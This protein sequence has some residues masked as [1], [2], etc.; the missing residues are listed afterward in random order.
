MSRQILDSDDENL[1]P[2]KR[3]NSDGKKDL[4]E[5]DY[6]SEQSIS[7]PKKKRSRLT[8][9]SQVQTS[10]SDAE[11]I[12]STVASNAGES[13]QGDGESEVENDDRGDEQ[14]G[15]KKRSEVSDVEVFRR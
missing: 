6:N 9:K 14:G 11:G 7:R 4:D 5:D 12:P 8:T 2:Q 3:K 15:V 10:K 13:E 1:I